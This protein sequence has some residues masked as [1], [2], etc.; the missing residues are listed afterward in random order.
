MRLLTS[1]R[2]RRL[3]AR[4]A[5]RNRA[6]G[7][8]CFYCGLPFEGAGGL[9]RTVDHRIPRTGGGSEGLPNLVFACHA[10]NQRKADSAEDA[11]LASEW[12]AARRLRS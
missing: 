8:R 9:R 2:L 5:R 4:R 10:C 7:A 11:F 12:L 3:D 6:D 1:F